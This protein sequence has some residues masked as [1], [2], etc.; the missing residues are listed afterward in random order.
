M[1]LDILT[2]S[3]KQA[4]IRAYWAT[5]GFSKHMNFQNYAVGS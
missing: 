3:R 2:V 1:L 5:Q 4:L